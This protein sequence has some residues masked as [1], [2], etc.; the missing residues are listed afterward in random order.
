[1]IG[2]KNIKGCLALRGFSDD[3]KKEDGR[4][5]CDQ[6]CGPRQLGHNQ[7]NCS[8]IVDLYSHGSRSGGCQSS[9]GNQ[10]LVLGKPPV[11]TA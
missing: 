11:W 7:Y 2:V 1:M 3:S 8:I 10:V 5:G 6:R 9:D 4:S